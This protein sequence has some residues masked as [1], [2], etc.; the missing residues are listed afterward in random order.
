MIIFQG[1]SG[2]VKM[3]TISYPVQFKLCTIVTCMCFEPCAVRW[4]IQRNRNVFIIIIIIVF[5]MNIWT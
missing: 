4:G 2:V 1:H 5:I 3:R